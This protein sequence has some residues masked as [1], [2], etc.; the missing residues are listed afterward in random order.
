M[1]IFEMIKR[2]VC[3]GYAQ[4]PL[5]FAFCKAISRFFRISDEAIVFQLLKKLEQQDAVIPFCFH[6]S[7]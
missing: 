5:F 1:I 4:S 3:T 6:F 7:K 2:H